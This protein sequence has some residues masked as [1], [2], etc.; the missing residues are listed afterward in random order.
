MKMNLISKTGKKIPI[1]SMEEVHE[2]N[3]YKRGFFDPSLTFWEHCFGIGFWI[4]GFVSAAVALLMG[5]YGLS[6]LIDYLLR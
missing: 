3:L 4:L 1:D 6:L 5:G 2:K